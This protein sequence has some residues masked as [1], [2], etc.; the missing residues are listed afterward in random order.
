M[1]GEVPNTAWSCPG[2]ATS[3]RRALPSL[4]GPLVASLAVQQRGQ[5]LPLSLERR[6]ILPPVKREWERPL[7]GQSDQGGALVVAWGSRLWSQNETELSAG[8]SFTSPEQTLTDVVSCCLGKPSPDCALDEVLVLP[9]FRLQ[10]NS[11]HCLVRPCRKDQ[12]L[13]T[14]LSPGELPASLPV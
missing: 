12:V 8:L 1:P 10:A 14:A 5:N 9:G 2:S 6:G 7:G 3:L 11:R 4:V 13:L